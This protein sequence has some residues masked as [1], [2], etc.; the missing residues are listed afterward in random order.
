M[1][2]LIIN[3]V[4]PGGSWFEIATPA[5]VWAPTRC[6]A[7][8]V[9][10][11]LVQC[12]IE[13]SSV[14]LADGLTV[15]GLELLDDRIDAADVVVVPT[16]PIEAVDVPD[17]LV[18]ALRRAHGRGA[19]LVGLCLGAFALAATGVLDGLSAVTHWHY[20]ERFEAMYPAIRFE[21]DTLYVDHG[22]AVTS[23]GSAAALDCCLHLVRRDHGAEAAATVARSLV[24]APHRSGTQSQFASAPPLPDGGGDPIT[25]AL[26]AAAVD[27]ADIAGVDDLAAA[28][29]V[30]RRTLERHLRNR[31]GVSPREWIGEQRL[32]L[33]SR[34]LE[35]RELSIDRVAELSGY[36]STASL[37]R[38][39]RAGRDA[40]P[41]EYRALF[42]GRADRERPEA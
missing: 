8:G 37:R 31:L 38:A 24:A 10:V 18:E 12:G 4:P 1:R 42:A 16:W 40:T 15:S 7:V 27:I 30:S 2:Q 23:A 13:G 39:F 22:H 32:V 3:V 25:T 20:R 9:D 34:L 28:A 14:A 5:G 11:D 19:R 36:G 6:R 26:N 17:R 21:P 29:R 41:G 33:A 35:R